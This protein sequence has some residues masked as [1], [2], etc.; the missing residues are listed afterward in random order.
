VSL[1]YNPALVH[2]DI[3]IDPR[4]SY[5]AELLR[6]TA[7]SHKRVVAVIEHDLLPYVEDKW[8]SL[9]KRLKPISSFL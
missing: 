5:M 2:K 6:Q 9:D 8:K 4:T 7:S 3:F 1:G